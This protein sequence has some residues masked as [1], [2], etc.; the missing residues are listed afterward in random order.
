MTTIWTPRGAFRRVPYKNEADLEAAIVEVSRDLFGEARHYLD[1]KRKIGTKAGV[2][3]IPDG[4]LIDLAD[5]RPR[6]FVVEAELASHDPLRHI[7]VQIL[8]FSLSFNDSPHAVKRVLLG[9]LQ[10]TP[11]VH[12]ACEAYARKTNYRN[13]DHLLDYLVHE[14]PFAALVIIDEVP[15]KLQSVLADSFSFGVEVLEVTRYE[16]GKGERFYHFEPFLADVAVDTGTVSTSEVDTVVV[17]ARDDGFEETFLGEN[18]WYAVRLH[19]TMRPQI[20][21]I[22]AYRVAPTSAITHVAPVKSIEPWKDSAK[23]V[24][25]FAEPAREV[26]PIKLLKDG[27]V[28]APQSLRYTTHKRLLAAKTLDDLW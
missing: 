20:E 10:E 19:G 15:E 3:T 4:Y 2:R 26:G 24:L 7:A 16:D 11:L 22:A 9:A 14:S 12:A 13:V 28:K 23:F 1:V 27:R 8:Q 17:P 18:R 6:L 21:Y 5:S 25:N